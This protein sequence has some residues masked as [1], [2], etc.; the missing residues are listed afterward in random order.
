MKLNFP[1]TSAK[2]FFYT[3]FQSVFFLLVIPFLYCQIN[4]KKKKEKESKT[5]ILKTH[6]KKKEEWKKKK[7]IMEIFS[8]K[9]KA[10][11][12]VIKTHPQ[13]KFEHIW[14][15]EFQGINEI[16]KS[17]EKWTLESGIKWSEKQLKKI[18]N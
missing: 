1:A 11:F 4:A 14:N 18:I 13:T 7:I 9:W 16:K 15:I 8:S 6:T 17:N 10:K 2:I 12:T 5:L 3:Y